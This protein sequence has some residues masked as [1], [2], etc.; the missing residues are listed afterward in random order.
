M[1]PAYDIE[2]AKMSVSVIIN[3]TQSPET[4]TYIVQKEVME[5]MLEICEQKEK[6]A[7]EISLHRL[8]G[9]EDGLMAVKVLKYVYHCP[10][11][12]SYK[13]HYVNWG[14]VGLQIIIDIRPCTLVLSPSIIINFVATLF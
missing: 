7:N 4:H 9:N 6:K 13:R 5:K 2:T 11:C 12:I 3:I 14:R 10:L 1:H 8:G